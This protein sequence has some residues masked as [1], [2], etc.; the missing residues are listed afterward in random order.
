MYIKILHN[1]LGNKRSPIE[2]VDW[3]MQDV[4]QETIFKKLC[5]V[6]LNAV[7]LN[8]LC[9]V[10]LWE[11]GETYRPLLRKKKGTQRHN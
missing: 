7:I 5:L 11:S 10:T 2:E 6:Y 3:I 8:F 1:T 9:L 4:L